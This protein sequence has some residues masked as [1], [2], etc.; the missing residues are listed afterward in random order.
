MFKRF[1]LLCGLLVSVV[2][3]QAATVDQTDP[4]QMMKQVAQNTFDRLAKDQGVIQS[5]PNHLKTVVDQELMPFV[6]EQYAAL[7]LLGS[8]LKGAKREDVM[9]FIKAF[10]GYL[11]T[12]YAQVLTQYNGQ[13]IEFGREPVLD[14]D[15]RIVGIQ[16]SIV[17]APNPNINLEFKLRK[18]KSGEWQAFDMVAEG[19][20]LLSAKQS[21]W[22][23]KIR[24]E[25]IAS[26]AKELDQLAAQPIKIEKKS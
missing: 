22:S 4:Y 26:V 19:I 2:S 11:V 8:N 24:K 12:N 16:V 18:D 23:D 1:A 7:K 17:D 20:S 13:K 15:E 10:R 25:G 9:A 5:N 6:N 14:G 21:E 3:V